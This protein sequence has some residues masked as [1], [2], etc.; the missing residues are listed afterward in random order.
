MAGQTETITF[1]QFD[2]EPLIE[3]WFSQVQESMLTD[4]QSTTQITDGF[5]TTTE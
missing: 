5:G 4:T 2:Q 3:K 1:V